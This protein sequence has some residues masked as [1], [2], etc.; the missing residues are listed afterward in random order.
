M[1]EHRKLAMTEQNLNSVTGMLQSYGVET[2]LRSAVIRQALGVLYM[3][4]HRLLSGESAATN[5]QL[6]R[7]NSFLTDP[8]WR[9]VVNKDAIPNLDLESFLGQTEMGE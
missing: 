5:D 6:A 2:Q 7:L 4:A 9:E 8:R 1:S 3:A